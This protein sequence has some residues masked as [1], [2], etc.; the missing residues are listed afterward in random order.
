MANRKVLFF[1]PTE[2]F[3]SEV[4][5]SDDYDVQS[6]KIVNLLDPTAAQDAAT[7]AY[8]DSVATGLLDWKNSV[9]VATTANL[10]ATRSGN[11]L[12]ATANGALT[13]D[14]V[15]VAVNDRILVKDQTTGADNG[16]YL[17]T[18][19]GDGSNPFVLTRT[20]DADVSSE[21]TAGL[22][23]FADQGTANADTAWVLSTNDPITLNTTALVFV[24]FASFAAVL[25]NAGLIKSGNNLAVEVDTSANAQGAGADGGSSGL[26]FDVT[27][28]AGK[29]RAA[30]NATG[31]LERSASGLAVRIDDTPDTLDA[32][33]DGLKVVGLPS[34]FKVNDTAVSA[35]VTAANLTALTAGAELANTIHFHG[36]IEHNYTASG[37]IDAF[38]A[39]YISA[40]NA[41]S[42]GDCSV[43]AES[44]VIGVAPAAISDT[45]T[46]R[47]VYEGIVTGALSGATAGTAYYLGTTGQPVLYGALTGN[48]RVVRLGYA[49]NAT[50]LDVH[51]MDLGKKS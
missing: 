19:T 23:V 27:G 12:T 20:T 26:E 22:Y 1:D 28:A 21:V 39:V 3:S 41:V 5:G 32:D 47:V 31:G 34:L 48:N 38:D 14:G 13:V 2:G 11:V 33:A 25:A 29:L 50:D 42:Q 40:N 37:A 24:Q 46:G 43:D 51:I 44:R 8:V 49:L 9:R 35:N 15:T 4:I 10:A 36:K 45:A 30:V 17:V 7:K 16:L 6:R 18:A